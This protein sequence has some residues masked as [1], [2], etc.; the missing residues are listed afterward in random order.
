VTLATSSVLVAAPNWLGDAVMALPAIADIRRRFP[1][2]HLYVAARSGVADLLRMSPLVD[3]VIT[4][5]WRGQFWNR[6]ALDVDA[7]RLRRCGAGIVVL[8]PNSFAGAYLMKRAGIPQRWGYSS[9]L[10]RGLLTRAV[11]RP[12]GP[13]H[14]AEYYQYLVSSLGMENGPL[15]PEISV[16]AVAVQRARALLAE[17]GWN[18]RSPLV[19][20]APGAAYGRAKQWIPSHVVRLVTALVCDHGTTCVLLGSRA[21][22]AITRQI[23]AAVPSADA[24]KVIDLAGETS[25]E[26]LAAVLAVSQ[27]CVANDSGAMHI[28]AAVGA[29]VVA[30]FGPTIVEATRPLVRRGGRAEVLT[31]RVWCRPCMLRECPIDHRCMVGI[32]PERVLA[33]LEAMR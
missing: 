4:L 10:R 26:L 1:A 15:E 31:H 24:D 33:T 20:L 12:R 29:P 13:V 28:A 22:A 8:M 18:G 2:S 17:R 7:E 5:E 3:E 25:L 6:R 21:D 9:D 30:I 27:A 32:T 11:T 23:Q 16:P 19:A 14:Q